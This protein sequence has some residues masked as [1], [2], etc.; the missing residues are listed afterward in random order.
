[1]ADLL[2]TAQMRLLEKSAIAAGRV[3]GLDLMERAGKGVVDHVFAHWPNMATGE[4]HAIVLCGPGNNGGD[5]YVIARLL[6][7]WAL[8]VTVFSVGDPNKLPPDARVNY[9]LWERI[10]EV[11]PLTHEAIEQLATRRDF[12]ESLLIDAV[13]GIGVNRALSPDLQICIEKLR[14]APEFTQMKTVAVDIQSG[15]CADSGRFLG[16]DP[17]YNDDLC[18]TFHRLKQ[19]H[20]L[21]R[22]RARSIRIVDIGLNDPGVLPA[23]RVQ[24]VTACDPTINK[25]MS[26]GHHKFGYGHAF[27]CAGGI[28]R[29]GAA[30]LAAR[31]ALRIGA[32]LVT[33][34]CPPAALMVN[35][36]RLDAVMCQPLKGAEALGQVLA[37]PRITA[38]CLG[39]GLGQQRAKELVPIAL[40]PSLDRQICLDADALSAWA[41]A[42]DALFRILHSG[43]VMTPHGGEFAR[44]FPDL[45]EQLADPATVG[46]GFS[47]LDAA[48]IAA[49]RA[50]C[51]VVFKGPDT[52]IASPDG[53]T[54][55]HSSF[56]DRVAPWLATAGS[57]DVLAGF[58]TGLLARGMDPHTA[59]ES[60]AWLHV[61]AARQVGP[62]LIAEDLPD[63]LMAVFCQIWP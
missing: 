35:A 17:R 14:C 37:D 59:A 48:V 46:S 28:A 63:A 54:S 49:Q 62:G 34:G 43:C 24:N 39:P 6:H 22:Q 50:G 33:V 19:G 57:G 30:R 26:A 5:G 45:A 29:G 20:V 52:V 12:G 51:T 36:A 25:A 2:T 15:V 60:A 32:G 42:P 61:E 11:C 16:P 10:G 41:D 58:V 47:K 23:P 7:Q 9:D 40:S 1:M 8:D 3:T 13:F 4:G 55:I 21:G 18:V 27:I 56:Y 44:L 38:V 53:R 31:S